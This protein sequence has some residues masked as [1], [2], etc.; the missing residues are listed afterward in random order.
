MSEPPQ[1]SVVVMAYKR[2]RFL[3]EAVES[4]LNQTA[5]REL[6]EVIVIKDFPDEELDPWF[7]ENGVRVVT[8]ALP[9]IGEMIFR[10]IEEAQGEFVCFLDDDD[11][12]APEKIAGLHHLVTVNPSLGLIRN[13]IRAIDV[14][15]KEI[16]SWERYRP[17][18]PESREFPRGRLALPWIYRYGGNVN[19]ST[20]TIRRSVLLDSAGAIQGIPASQDISLFTLAVARY[21]DVR[22]ESNRWN[23]Y[24]VHPSTSH[25]TMTTGAEAMDYR[26]VMRSVTSGEVVHATLR[27]RGVNP[28]ARK[29]SGLYETET[30]AVAFLL[31]QR[32]EFSLGGWARLVRS[33]FTRRQ[34]Y[35]GQMAAYCLFRWMNPEQGSRLYAGRRAGELRRAAGVTS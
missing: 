10:G 11:R 9:W 7:A 21:V 1:F 19:M 6:F 24:R 14:E 25:P 26:D 22:I 33:A 27:R 13:S 15:G 23:D 3:R 32:A 17:Q 18:A 30:K 4:V 12:F 35:L 16:G 34:A 20:M 31:D 5:P 29:M 28:V 2:R 8:E